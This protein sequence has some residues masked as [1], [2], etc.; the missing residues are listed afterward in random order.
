MV[1][2]GESQQFKV[3]GGNPVGSPIAASVTPAGFVQG[4][5]A[6]APTVMGNP[7]FLAALDHLFSDLVQNTYSLSTDSYSQPT[8]NW[9]PPNVYYLGYLA[10]AADWL[11]GGAPSDEDADPLTLFLA[12]EGTKGK[13]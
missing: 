1:D 5:V 6:P 3:A 2:L 11:N 12:P 9:Y 13:W 7:L 10:S 8:A 4:E